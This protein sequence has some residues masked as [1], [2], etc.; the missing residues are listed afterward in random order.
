MAKRLSTILKITFYYSIHF[1][2]KKII[3]NFSQLVEMAV[4][5]SL[6]VFKQDPYFIKFDLEFLIMVF[7][8]KFGKLTNK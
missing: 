7:Q 4:L 8:S 6:P 3:Q 5:F 1:N 2:K